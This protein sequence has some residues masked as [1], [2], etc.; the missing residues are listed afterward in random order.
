MRSE[1]QLAF[2]TDYDIL[3]Y[4]VL[5]VEHIALHSASSSGG[6]QFYIAC[7]QLNITGGGSANPS[8][9]SIPGVYK[10]SDPGILISK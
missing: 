4:L 1:W 9:V 7:A 2:S 5:V 10:A 8:T 6:A 3:K